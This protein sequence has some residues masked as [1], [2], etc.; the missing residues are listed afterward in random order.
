MKKNTDLIL[1]MIHAGYKTDSDTGSVWHCQFIKQL[2]MN[3]QVLS[4]QDKYSPLEKPGNIYTRITN[5]TQDVLE[6]RV[7]ALEG[8]IGALALAIW[9]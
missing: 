8:G 7:A 3:F 1:N 4:M 5:P 2:P 6:K 9:S